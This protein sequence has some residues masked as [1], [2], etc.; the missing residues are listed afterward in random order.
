MSWVGRKLSMSDDVD[1]KEVINEYFMIKE[2]EREEELK[3]FWEEYGDE[4]F[5]GEERQD[6]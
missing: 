4:Y 2:K 6:G 3:K 1:Q 5:T